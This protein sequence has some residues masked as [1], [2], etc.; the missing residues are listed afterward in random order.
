MWPS[1]LLLALLF[2]VFLAILITFIQDV[3]VVAA[4][5]FIIYLIAIRFTIEIRRGQYQEY[6]GGAALSAV[7]L[8]LVG[9]ELPLWMITTFI[10]QAFL[11]AQLIK[12]G[13][14]YFNK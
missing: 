4:N 7:I 11:I 3:I 9:N 14:R 12:I 1:I 6:A 13:R 5:A 8:L 2:I 10:L